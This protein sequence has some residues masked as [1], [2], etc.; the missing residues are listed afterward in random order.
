[1][2][3]E[4]VRLQH[5]AGAEIVAQTERVT[6]LVR[7]DFDDELADQSFLHGVGQRAARLEHAAAKRRLLR[8]AVGVITRS[9]VPAAPPGRQRLLRP[10]RSGKHRRDELFALTPHG[11]D[12]AF[13]ETNVRIVNLAGEGIGPRRAN[14]EGRIDTGEPTY[15]VVTRVGRVPVRVVGHLFDN[16]GVLEADLFKCLVPEE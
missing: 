2:V 6:D 3:V 13:T 15:G 5:G 9:P 1:E 12:D 7:G 8:Q 16:E 10:L 14:G 4:L 11:A